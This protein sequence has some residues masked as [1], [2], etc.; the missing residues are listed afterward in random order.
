MMNQIAWCV[1]RGTAVHFDLHQ[2]HEKAHMLYYEYV[3]ALSETSF[4]ARFAAYEALKDTTIER[5]G[6][7]LHLVGE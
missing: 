3:I 6:S 7:N 1:P 5:A 4:V 2:R